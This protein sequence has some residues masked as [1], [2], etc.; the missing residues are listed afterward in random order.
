VWEKGDMDLNI[1]LSVFAVIAGPEAAAPVT[2]D[3][4]VPGLEA[5]GAGPEVA[6]AATEVVVTRMGQIPGAKIITRRDVEQI[7]AEEQKRQL[8]GCGEN[9]GCLANL[10]GALDAK[11][12][13]WGTVTKVGERYLV[14][15]NLIE[16]SSGAVI[17]RVGRQAVGSDNLIQATTEATDALWQDPTLPADGCVGCEDTALTPTAG[18]LAVKL[19][20]NFMGAFSSKVDMGTTTPTLDIDLGY[21]VWR[22]WTLLLASSMSW[23]SG[24]DE[25]QNQK[26]H[27]QVIPVNWGIR[28]TWHPGPT[29]A[30]F[31]GGGF[32]VGFVRAALSGESTH[33]SSTF[34][35][36]ASLGGVQQVFRSLGLLAE[37]GYTLTSSSPRALRSKPLNAA[38]LRLGLAYGF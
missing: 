36:N 29:F 17:R 18:Q 34:S 20:N 33:T 8:L 31:G 22:N 5:H 12:L 7:L 25:T 16:V 10:A 6:V 13:L 38:A 15:L 30:L 3:V 9:V 14:T 21:R 2:L 37:L 1:I 27:F 26:V 19:G 11:Q 32:G 4:V 28:Y 35:F 23:G 24:T